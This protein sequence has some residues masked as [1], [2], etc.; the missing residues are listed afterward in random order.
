MNKGFNAP[1]FIESFTNNK[2]PESLIKYLK[3]MN[4]K[5]DLSHIRLPGGT[6]S[7]DYSPISG[8]GSWKF[9][10]GRPLID[11]IPTLKE[12]NIQVLWVANLARE[13]QINEL[14]YV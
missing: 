14:I 4:A 2:L 11:Y 6:V 1:R 7:Q 10:G 12:L 3:E 5:G 13:N 9:E 8:G